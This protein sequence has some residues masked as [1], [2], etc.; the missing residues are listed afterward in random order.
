MLPWVVVI[1][2]LGSSLLWFLIIARETA[3]IDDAATPTVHPPDTPPVTANDTAA[4][5]EVAS[6]L[7]LLQTMSCVAYGLLPLSATVAL[8][9]L[10]KPTVGAC[11]L[12]QLCGVAWATRAQAECIRARTR[13]WL[14]PW[15]RP[16]GQAA[17]VTAT[18][19]VSSEAG[20]VSLAGAVALANALGRHSADQALLLYPV[21]LLNIY[22]ASLYTRA[23]L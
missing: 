4:P 18:N 15:A 20:A 6:G 23:V 5:V 13:P 16:H 12:L 3:R 19:E 21:A 10:L 8:L 1:W 2:V 11:Y 9:A 17:A 14:R 22:F 7:T